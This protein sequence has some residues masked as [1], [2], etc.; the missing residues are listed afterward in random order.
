MADNNV[1]TMVARLQDE[2]P[3]TF[4]AMQQR[5]QD[6]ARNPGIRDLGHRFRDLR[7]TVEPI[8]HV[9]KESM[10][11]MLETLGITTLSLIGAI[12]GLASGM[13]KFSAGALNMKALADQARLTTNQLQQLR[14]A[15]DELDVTTEQ[16]DQTVSQFAKTV[17]EITGGP[18]KSPTG[19][20]LD[21]YGKMIG[22]G[23][24]ALLQFGE[25]QEH[26][27]NFPGDTMGAFRMIFE[28]MDKLRLTSDKRALWLEAWGVPKR[29]A[30]DFLK[31]LDETK[32]RV[33]LNTETAREF[34]KE[35]KA[36]ARDVDDLAK[37][38]FN[39]VGPTLTEIIKGMREFIADWEKSG[40]PAWFAE[41][42]S[43]SLNETTGK[44]VGGIARTPL[45]TNQ[46]WADWLIRGPHGTLESQPQSRPQ[47]QPPP[48]GGGV[49]TGGAGNAFQERAAREGAPPPAA[50]PFSERFGGWEGG[51]AMRAPST[52]E[53]VPGSRPAPIAPGQRGPIAPDQQGAHIPSDVTGS[54]YLRAQRASFTEELERDPG[55]RKEL[56]A[57]TTLEHESD[58]VA[59]VESLANRHAY[60][61]EARAKQGLPPLSV[62]DMIHGAGGKSFYGPVRR[63]SLGSRVAELERNPQR[64]A[65]MNAAIAEVSSGSNILKGATDQGS[66]GDPNAQHPGGRIVR[67]G[68]VYNDWGGGP[69]SHEGA[70]RF[71]EEQQR[72]VRGEGGG[73]ATVQQSMV[74]RNTSEP[75]T[76][77]GQGELGGPAALAYARQHLGDDE[78]RDNAKL[79]QFFSAR[80]IKINPAATAWCAAYVNA[81]LGMAG[82]RGTGSLAAGSFTRY[83]TGV[84]PEDVQGGDIGVVRGT[85][86]RTGIEG[87]HVGFLTGERRINP[88]TGQ[89][90]LQM[91]G[92]N[93]PG[94]VSGKGGVSERWY[95]ASQLHLRRAPGLDRALA[96]QTGA[97][98]AKGAADLNIDVKAPRGTTVDA[99]SRGVFTETKIN[100]SM[101][102][103]REEA[104][105]A[106][107]EKE[108]EKEDA[109]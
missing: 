2:T 108:K 97:A 29:L 107:E 1:L 70:R 20:A 18:D 76:T 6:A 64:L 9:L 89:L 103:D 16:M 90:E 8:T 49:G 21:I 62:K 75:A 22:F 54:E 95:S 4:R 81:N 73:T 82:I 24:R 67:Q 69:G 94:T 105:P 85:S 50:T 59:V 56:A 99:E 101:K 43:L 14:D 23:D 58:P 25:I 38:I 57:L 37:T 10:M 88:R 80:G 79:S 71:R 36:I 61:N 86:P 72:R 39:I 41:F 19:G 96:A 78:I 28:A 77:A 35:W 40:P 87:K 102:G 5:F 3:A 91:V 60:V 93:Q 65:K 63:G 66:P 30:E 83:G 15:A 7:E 100:R 48:K 32:G 45:V 11:P 12:G 92:G 53:V 33:E 109:E 84:S 68:E 52:G 106:A 27:K 17:L 42:M 74:D 26:L 13:Q 31:T 104:K 55:A 34:N 44:I 47:P 98:P 51:G 46:S